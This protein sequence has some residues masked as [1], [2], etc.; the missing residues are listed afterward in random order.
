MKITIEPDHT[1]MESGTGISSQVPTAT[2]ARTA[3]TGHR[4]PL[5]VL[6]PAIRWISPHGTAF[7]LERPPMHLTFN[8]TDRTKDNLRF[9]FQLPLPWIVYGF[10]FSS[11]LKTLISL[12]LYARNYPLSF[13][14]DELSML[15]LPNVHNNSL[16]CLGQG[17]TT[18]YANWAN[19]MGENLTAAAAMAQVQGLFWNMAANDDVPTW[20]NPW[21]LPVQLPPQLRQGL[22]DDNG[23]NNDLAVAILEWYQGCS[24]PVI[25]TLQYGRS[26]SILDEGD[27]FQALTDDLTRCEVSN[28]QLGPQSGWAELTRVFLEAKVIEIN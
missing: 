9:S 28:L 11:K 12:R 2:F 16:A 20:L 24:L 15:P 10:E 21:R 23:Y 3:E 6:P 19:E 4:V 17:F 25:A 26:N 22:G 7:V 1:T 5:G 14:M 27:T 18:K 8:Y 13:P